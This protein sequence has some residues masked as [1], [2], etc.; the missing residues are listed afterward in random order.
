MPFSDLCWH[1]CWTWTAFAS[2][3][4]THP[5]SRHQV[6]LAQKWMLQRARLAGK[7]G[8]V[9]GQVMESMAASPRPSRPEI[10][11]VVN[12]VYDG[13]DGIVL[14]QVSTQPQR[15]LT[16]WMGPRKAAS[17]CTCLLCV[18]VH[19]QY[20][21]NVDL[22]DSRCPA[23]AHSLSHRRPPAGSLLM[24]RSPRWLPS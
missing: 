4:S 13:A 14:M 20:T 16:V 5:P 7:P 12:A 17:C 18:L 22:F 10:T 1:R 15:M 8:L 9:A 6:A 3:P 23:L 21:D 2:H 11:D 19:L 24:W